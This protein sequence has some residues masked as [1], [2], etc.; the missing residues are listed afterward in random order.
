MDEFIDSQ[1]DKW[2]MNGFLAK[3]LKVKTLLSDST[4]LVIGSAEN[5]PDEI[6]A[7]SYPY[8]ELM[9]LTLY[10]FMWGKIISSA[11]ESGKRGQENQVYFDGLIKN[12]GFFLDRLLPRSISLVEEIRAGANSIMET[13]AEQF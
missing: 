13:T 8:M 5:N 12:G 2:E 11:I 3:F 10:C 6:G 4:K 7:A 9:G 1:K